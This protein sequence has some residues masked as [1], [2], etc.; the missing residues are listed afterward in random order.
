MRLVLAAAGQ[1]HAEPASAV[2]VCVSAKPDTEQD[3]Q[4]SRPVLGGPGFLY[5]VLAHSG[6]CRA[7]QAAEGLGKR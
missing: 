5:R 6:S 1:V 4:C 2:G 7:L 3:H